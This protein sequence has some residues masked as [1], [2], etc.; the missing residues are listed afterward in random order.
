[1]TKNAHPKEDL[2]EALRAIVSLIG[3]LVKVG[4]RLRKGT[5]QATL[6]KNRLKALR[7]ASALIRKEMRKR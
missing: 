3:K 1:M 6:L 2:A 4:K 7:I 5:P